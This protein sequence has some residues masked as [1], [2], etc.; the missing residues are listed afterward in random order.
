MTMIAVCESQAEQKLKRNLTMISR[1]A[2]A[3]FFISSLFC[4]AGPSLAVNLT[5]SQLQEGVYLFRSERL[6]EGFGMVSGNGLIV[7]TGNAKAVLLDTPW[8]NE[9]VD[10][11]F[12]WLEKRNL[13]LEAV[14]ATHSH[15]DAGGHLAR[16]HEQAVPTWAYSLTNTF[17][18]EQGETPALNGFEGSAWIV[19]DEIEVFFPGPGHT[20]DNSVVWIKSH[21]LLFGGCFIREAATFS[22]GYTA[23]GDVSA[24][25][26][27]VSRVV[28]RYPDAQV[29][30]PGHGEA[31]DA[32]LLS[33]TRQLALKAL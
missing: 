27:S 22:L 13:E 3:V 18:M 26:D 21:N 10:T 14:V 9:D 1:T 17:F 16:F 33:H 29:V 15:E 30:V 31:G 23:E 6:V 7:E 24:W 28:S 20:L 19:P 11:L 4:V 12:T 25:P 5:V 2:V 8:D 32:G